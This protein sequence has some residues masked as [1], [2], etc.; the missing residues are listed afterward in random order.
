MFYTL[1]DNLKHISND[2]STN[3][4]YSIDK[5][6]YIHIELNEKTSAKNSQISAK[7]MKIC[8]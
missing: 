7:K 1:V 4:I 6:F 8:E 3:Q 5:T 2:F